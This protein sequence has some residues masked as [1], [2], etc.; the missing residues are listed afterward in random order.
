MPAQHASPPPAP[1]ISPSWHSALEEFQA[2]LLR[3]AVAVKTRHAYAIDSSQFA[4]WATHA[5]LEPGSIDV[6]AL[7]RYAAGLSE[8]GHAP[9]TI[10]RKLAALRGLFRAQVE[11]GVREENPAEL[12]SSPKKPQHLPRVLRPDEV[13]ELLDRI[14][15]TTPLELRDRAL[16]ELAYAS[17]LRAEELVS[18]DLESID[19]DAETVRVE[20]KGGKT[21]V[22]PAGEPALRAIERYLARGR[23]ALDLDSGRSLFLSKSGRRLGTSDVRRRL[24]TWARQ[25]AA[26]APALAEAHPHALRHSF[27]THLLEGGAD[28]RAIQELLGHATISTTQVYTRVES[29]RLRSAYASAHP[30]A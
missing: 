12:V 26:H 5:G 6:R 24:R 7:R 18:L 9:S 16:F 29:A 22:V 3:R 13:A 10:A 11:L 19:F 2:D 1:T 17:G 28:L 4:A 23:P 21:R 27:A 25:A 8:R 15:V 30:R 14:P 20:G